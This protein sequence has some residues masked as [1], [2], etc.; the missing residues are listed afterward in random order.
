[1]GTHSN[2]KLDGYCNFVLEFM[3][4]ND[5]AATKSDAI[6]IAIREYGN[7]IGAPSEKEYLE[8]IAV[9]KKF[10]EI[11]EGTRSGKIKTISEKKFI[12]AYSKRGV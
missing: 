11:Q 3:V 8:Q 7:K 5:L 10:D 9:Q 6:R 1:M 12:E 2:Y 4:K